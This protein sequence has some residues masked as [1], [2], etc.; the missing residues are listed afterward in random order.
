MFPS[1]AL[2]F[3]AWVTNATRLPSS[4]TAGESDEWAWKATKPLYSYD[5]HATILHLLGVDHEKLTYRHNG[6]DRRDCGGTPIGYKVFKRLER[7][8]QLQVR[9]DAKVSVPNQTLDLS[10][11]L[12]NL[13]FQTA[14]ARP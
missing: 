12:C 8:P 10:I 5:L 3:V 2:R 7:T 13:Q 9:L 6:S 1:V 11:I 4:S 14:S